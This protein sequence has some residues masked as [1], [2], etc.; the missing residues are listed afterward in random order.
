MEQQDF[1][2]LSATV[3]SAKADGASLET[4]SIPITIRNA[5]SMGFQKAEVAVKDEGSQQ[6]ATAYFGHIPARTTST[7]NVQL[8][9]GI[10]SCLYRITPDVGEDIVGGGLANNAPGVN[11]TISD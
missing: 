11:I 9:G 3:A 1:L 5:S 2:E 4:Y 10:E 7:Q 8:P 6:V